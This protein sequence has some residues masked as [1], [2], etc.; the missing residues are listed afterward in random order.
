MSEIF[1]FDY[2]GLKVVKT[3]QNLYFLRPENRIFFN[4]SLTGLS[5][6][7]LVGNLIYLT[8]LLLV[9]REI[10]GTTRSKNILLSVTDNCWGKLQFNWVKE[11]T[12]D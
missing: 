7:N 6:G 9:K 1:K 10:R 3:D 11:L 4:F 2:L 12:W 5:V 8:L